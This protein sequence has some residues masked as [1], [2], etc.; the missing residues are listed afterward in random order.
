MTLFAAATSSYITIPPPF[1]HA[2]SA[3]GP[4][5]EVHALDAASGALREKVQQLLFVPPDELERAD[6]TRVALRYGSHGVEVSPAGYA[7]VPVL[8][9]DAIE[10]FARDAEG[11]L[12]HVA[13]VQSP[14][15]PDAR[16]GPRHVKIHPNGRVLYCVTEHS[17]LVDAY[18][19]TPTGLTHLSSRSL[20]PPRPTPL[21]PSSFRGD[22]LVLSPSTPAH[23][24]PRAL[25][26][27]TRGASAS[28]RGWLSV[29][30]LD[31]DG[32]FLDS[33]EY[34]EAPTSGGKAHA[35]D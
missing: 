14:R 30:L 35:L 6:K 29:F 17:N 24:A 3:G 2:Y 23:P 10:M 1:T 20:L 11:R 34:W 27:S 33:D 21:S 16:D 25:F 13:S 5:G 28:V 19:I 32:L 7:F 22:T 9:T 18:K 15:G 8:G 26:G 12:E 31:A 4:T